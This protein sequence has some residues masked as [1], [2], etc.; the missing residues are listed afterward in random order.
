MSEIL[1][2]DISPRFE[3]NLTSKY[4]YAKH[5]GSGKNP[6]MIVGNSS[7]S[8]EGVSSP[9]ICR[10]AAAVAMRPRVPSHIGRAECDSV[11]REQPF[12]KRG[13]LLWP[14]E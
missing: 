1:E 9:N 3:K 13:G 14:K 6:W 2:C 7:P 10:A 11:S 12:K 5:N 8:I 4:V